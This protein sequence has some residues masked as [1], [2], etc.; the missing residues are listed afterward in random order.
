MKY[1]FVINPKAG[2]GKS[3]GEIARKIRSF[4]SGKNIEYNIYLSECP[5]DAIRFSRDCPV[6]EE[7]EACFVAC[8]GDGTFFEVVN[9]GFERP[10]V[11]FACYPCGSGNDF[12]KST[13]GKAADYRDF[14]KLLDGSTRMIDV[15]DCSGHICTNMCNI[16]LDSIICD[17]MNRFKK[18]PLVSGPMAYNISTGISVLGKLGI[19]M[20]LTFDDGE[21]YEGSLTLSAFGNGICYGGG[22]YPTPEA[23]LDDGLI[24]FCGIKKV[25]LSQVG[26]LIGIYK[27]GKHLQSE[28]IK[29]FLLYK[30]I[31]SVRIESDEDLSIC[32]DGEVY[33]GTELD[34][35]I[36]PASLPF[37]VPKFD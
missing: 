10:G 9:G 28:E 27:S 4:F 22:Y 5:G 23:K 8:G 18:I 7:E 35:S 11:S 25:G 33:H 29:P 31:K 37:R 12:I 2:K 6:P 19:P 17:R 21:V 36:R 3:A 15:L 30:K 34:I 20:K 24:D 26:R 13:G 1:V 14:Q 32:M 16:G